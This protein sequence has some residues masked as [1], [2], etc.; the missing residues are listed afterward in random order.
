MSTKEAI[1]DII[2]TMPESFVDEVFHYV[3]FLKRQSEDEVYNADFLA[4]I[5]RG[6]KQFA[7]GCGLRRDI[8]EVPE[9]E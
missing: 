5:E 3:S 1:F 9:Y 2:D 6:K 7:E 4:M 8:I